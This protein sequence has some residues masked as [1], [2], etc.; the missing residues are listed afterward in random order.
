MTDC[1]MDPYGQV[2]QVPPFGHDDWAREYLKDEFPMENKTTP[3]QD[4]PLGIATW[5]ERGFCDSFE[6]T[7]SM[8]GWVRYSTVMNQWAYNPDIRLTK[9]QLNSIWEWGGRIARYTG[10]PFDYE[11]YERG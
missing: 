10:Y 4:G 8:R 7:L 11:E 3:L 1:W 5:E 2:Y 6:N 9:A